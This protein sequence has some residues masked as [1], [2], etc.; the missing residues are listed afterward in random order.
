MQDPGG[1][2]QT[3]Q[4]GNVMIHG[5]H[6]DNKG[7]LAGHLVNSKAVGVFGCFF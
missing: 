4:Q 2:I 6:K 3:L 5:S 1:N 7:V